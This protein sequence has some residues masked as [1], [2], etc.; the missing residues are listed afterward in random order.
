MAFLDRGDSGEMID[1][2]N[3]ACEFLNEGRITDVSGFKL[4]ARRD[5]RT[6]SCRQI[7][8]DDNANALIEQSP[9]KMGAYEPCS[10]GNE[11]GL[12]LIKLQCIALNINGGFCMHS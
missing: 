9:R 10:P 6:R 11:S 2:L 8:E 12:Q 5:V 3:P 4:R 7:V 1:D